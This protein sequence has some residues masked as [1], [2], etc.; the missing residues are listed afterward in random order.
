[1]PDPGTAPATPATDAEDALP[2][3]F[4]GFVERGLFASHI[5][6]HDLEPNHAERLNRQLFHDLDEMTRPRPALRPGL[7]WQTEQVM[8]DFEEFDE[9]MGLFRAA[10]K[11]ILD[12]MRVEYDD[13]VITGAWANI[14]P[15]GAPHP[16]HFHPNNFLSG[17]YYVQ[18]APGGDRI[19]FHEPRPQL[20]IIAP[21]VLE[22]T[23]YT[24]QSEKVRVK[25]GRL[26]MFPAW[27]T[28]SVPINDSPHLRISVAFNVMFT[29]FTEKMSRPR[30]Q[31]IPLRRK[32]DRPET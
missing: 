26:V 21:R 20:D 2:A 28:H 23:R 25:P 32:S 11:R 31:G 7:T 5:W 6:V 8:Q 1:M 13:F 22:P 19:L 3:P 17:V 29:S 18:A 10:S 14:N 9:L 24:A 16:P 12:M 27:L 30:W 4:A 15:K